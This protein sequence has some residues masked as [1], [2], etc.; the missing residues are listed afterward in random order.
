MSIANP[1]ASH[2]TS[3]NPFCTDLG[4]SQPP[5]P[6][7][8][9]VMYCALRATPQRG[10]VWGSRSRAL[11]GIQ[12]H[13]KALQ[14]AARVPVK[15]NTPR[16]SQSLLA[17]T[18]YRLQKDP[19]A[20]ATQGLCCTPIC[21]D[22]L[23]VLTPVPINCGKQRSGGQ[24]FKRMPSACPS[25]A[26]ASNETFATAARAPTCRAANVAFAPLCSHG[27]HGLDCCRCN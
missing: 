10:M 7:F 8:G 27:S 22:P 2:P 4:G 17:Y 12:Q 24:D 26:H 15:T 18:S 5:S 19:V 14:N 13:R 11:K 23:T 21:F 16:K 20:C 3:P 1:N 9:R 6:T 25:P